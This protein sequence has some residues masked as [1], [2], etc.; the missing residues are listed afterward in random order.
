M[1]HG[2]E[3]R[4]LRILHCFRSPVGGIFRHIRD[5]TEYHSAAGYEIGILCDS[6]TGGA[7]ED[8]LFEDILPLLKLGLTRIPIRRSIAPTDLFAMKKA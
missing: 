7:H 8:R 6:H 5:L 3:N 4:P 2:P 1:M